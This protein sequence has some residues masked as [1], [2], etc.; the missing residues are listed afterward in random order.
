MGG[1]SKTLA[2]YYSLMGEFG[3]RSISAAMNILEGGGTLSE[4]ETA[5]GSG[6]WVEFGDRSK[7]FSQMD[8]KDRFGHIFFGF[9]DGAENSKV[10]HL[11]IVREAALA[12]GITPVT[13]EERDPRA[14]WTTSICGALWKGTGSSPEER[15]AKFLTILGGLREHNYPPEGTSVVAAYPN[16][17]N[18]LYMKVVIKVRH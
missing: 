12:L 1:Q 15:A 11:Q 13:M 17:L 2:D 3:A 14:K 9:P 18:S 6:M 10:R 4:G 16:P 5:L 8:P 7:D